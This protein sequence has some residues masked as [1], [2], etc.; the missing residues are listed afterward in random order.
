[1]NRPP[2]MSAA[3]VEY[4]RGQFRQTIADMNRALSTE[5]NLA[6]FTFAP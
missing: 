5:G 3:R 6:T 1:M 4:I 2:G